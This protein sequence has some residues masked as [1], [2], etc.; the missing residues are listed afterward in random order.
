M[1]R[2]F[3]AIY[4]S[5]EAVEHLEAFVEVRRE[6]GRFRWTFPTHWHLTLAFFEDVPERS[7]EALVEGLEAAV[8]KR[9]S[10]TAAIAGGG[11]FPHVGRAK[12]LW[13]GVDVDDAAE[14][15]KLAKG[16]RASGATAGA[17]PAGERLRPHLTLARINPPIE[18]T[19]WVRLLDA[20]RGPN[21]PIDEVALV[22]SHLGEGPKRRPRHEVVA[23]FSFS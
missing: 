10:L 2:T 5:P 3:V 12:V 15:E 22:E 11:A 20:Y 16:C 19:K 9:T 1:T 4:P 17:P 6:C 8:G 18:A 13:A 7:F 23:T 14:L 21:W